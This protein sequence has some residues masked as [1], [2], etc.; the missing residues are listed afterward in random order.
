MCPKG[1]RSVVWVHVAVWSCE[2]PGWIIWTQMLTIEGLFKEVLSKDHNL[3]NMFCST[4]RHTVVLPWKPHCSGLS[5]H[6]EICNEPLP[7]SE[8][9]VFYCSPFCVLFFHR[10]PTSPP[11]YCSCLPLHASQAF[12]AASFFY[13]QSHPDFSF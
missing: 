11:S 10:C 9:M 12:C 2:G 5:Q 6:D 4:C 3:T 1:K 8:P 13:I 7:L